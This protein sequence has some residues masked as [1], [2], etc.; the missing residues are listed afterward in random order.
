VN[1]YFI[2][3]FVCVGVGFGLFKIA[4]VTNKMSDEIVKLREE[5]ANLLMFIQK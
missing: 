1:P 2:V 4:D 5:N 3:A